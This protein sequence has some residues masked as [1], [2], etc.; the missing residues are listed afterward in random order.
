MKFKFNY[1]YY[2]N[3][4]TFYGSTAKIIGVSKYD[5]YDDNHDYISQYTIFAKSDIDIYIKIILQEYGGYE[6]FGKDGVFFVT[7]GSVKIENDTNVKIEEVN[8]EFNE[9]VNKELNEEFNEELNEEFNEESDFSINIRKITYFPINELY[10]DLKSIMCC[11]NEYKCDIFEVS[12]FG[13]ERTTDDYITR[14][15]GFCKLNKNLFKEK[16]FY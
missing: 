4:M 16:K 9:E 1:K 13:N 5:K 10:L 14:P 7:Y 12:R 15:E 2:N 11:N 3:R 8:K 6:S